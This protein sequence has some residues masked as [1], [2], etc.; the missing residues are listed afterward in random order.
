MKNKHPHYGSDR[1]QKTE[2]FAIGAIIY[3]GIAVLVLSLL[4]G[5]FR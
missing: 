4:A 1:K 5:I 3:C 2:E